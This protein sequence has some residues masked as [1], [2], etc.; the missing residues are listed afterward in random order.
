MFDPYSIVSLAANQFTLQA[1]TY[2]IDW[3]AVGYRVDAHQ[4]FLKNVTDAITYPGVVQK[5]DS[6]L[7]VNSGQSS[8]GKRVITITAA[9]V[10][11]LHHY[12]Q[13]VN[14]GGFGSNGPAGSPVNCVFAKV[15]ITQL[16]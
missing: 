8:T 2:S 5:S 3:E 11:E 12:M 7:G 13:T 16:A 9:K 4:S 6:T 1:G 15:E 10:F 14:A